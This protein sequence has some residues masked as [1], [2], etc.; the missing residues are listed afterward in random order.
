[1]KGDAGTRSGPME[2]ISTAN[3]AGANVDAAIAQKP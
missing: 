2:G 1:L 3:V